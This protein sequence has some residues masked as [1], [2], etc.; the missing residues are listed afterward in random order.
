MG[1]RTGEL[2]SCRS[3]CGC[4]EATITEHTL[5]Q[6]LQKQHLPNDQ[7]LKSCPRQ[8]YSTA[9]SWAP[10]VRKA[11]RITGL[12][13]SA[14]VLVSSSSFLFLKSLLWIIFPKIRSESSGWP[15]HWKTVHP[16][17]I[18]ILQR[19]DPWD[20]SLH[21]DLER[22]LGLAISLRNASCGASL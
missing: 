10:R 8:G 15:F 1:V 19:G 21:Q 3:S 4:S 16:C 2:S 11:S 20:G 5:R 7:S 14:W 17:S 18:W 6:T 13:T 9:R 12:S 22:I